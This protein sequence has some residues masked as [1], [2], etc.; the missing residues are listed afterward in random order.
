MTLHCVPVPAPGFERN[1]GAYP[2]LM[3][4]DMRLRVQF[5]NGYID[6]KHTYTPMQLRWGRVGS[7]W[8]IGAVAAADAVIPPARPVNGSYE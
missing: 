3:P 5:A 2:D 4:K 7:P 8:D 6:D 1:P